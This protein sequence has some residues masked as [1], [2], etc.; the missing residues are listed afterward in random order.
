MHIS[1]HES[2]LDDQ[3]RHI[4]FCGTHFSIKFATT[5]RIPSIRCLTRPQALHEAKKLSLYLLENEPESNFNYVALKFLRIVEDIFPNQKDVS[6]TYKGQE[7]DLVPGGKVTNWTAA[8]QIHG[9]IKVDLLSN[10]NTTVLSIVWE[11][12]DTDVALILRHH[13]LHYPVN[14]VSAR[15]SKLQLKAIDGY[16]IIEMPDGS[17]W[18]IHDRPEAEKLISARL[19]I[20]SSLSSNEVS[21]LA[22]ELNK[23]S[24]KVKILHSPWDA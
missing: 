10:D 22:S 14:K 7:I 9:E 8:Q 6:S 19:A 13:L 18:V 3:D 12:T 21:K 20:P 17:E 1:D 24:S 2:L 16:V 23:I 4:Q 5:Y 11:S 15:A